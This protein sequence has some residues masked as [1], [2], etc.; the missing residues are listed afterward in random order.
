MYRDTSAIF[1]QCSAVLIKL[2]FLRVSQ[3]C[4]NQRV[5]LFVF[6]ES[7]ISLAFI[8]KNPSSSTTNSVCTMTLIEREPS[9]EFREASHTLL[10]NANYNV[11]LKCLRALFF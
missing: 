6:R 2:I 8:W 3:Q 11:H 10:Q 1:N 9:P 7:Q 5:F 4:E